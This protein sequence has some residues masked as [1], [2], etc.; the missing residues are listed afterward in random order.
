V[1]LCGAFLVWL[2]RE[3]RT[4]LNGR[5]LSATWDVEELVEKRRKIEDEDLLKFGYRV[6]A[7][8]A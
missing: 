4:W 5:L 6:G 7:P 8:A 3:R 1:G 2:C